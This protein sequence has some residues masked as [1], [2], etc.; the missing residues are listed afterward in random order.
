MTAKCMWH[1]GVQQ[2]APLELQSEPNPPQRIL[3]VDDEPLIRHLSTKVLAGC[4][5]QVDT[6]EDGAA[7]WQALNSDSY[8]LL[9]TD[10]NMPKVSGVELLKML[11]AARMTLPVIMVS[12]AMPTDELSW[13]PWLQI[14][15]SLA[16]PFSSAALL[17]T[18]RRV[19]RVADDARQQIEPPP[20]WQ[21]EPSAAGLR[22]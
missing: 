10:N 5:Y 16:K 20:N 17:E 7:A 18:V 22:L 8:D 11:H 13:H 4:G 6:A 12:G 2:S 3:V 9:V 15:A 1:A 14:D 19:L 21:N